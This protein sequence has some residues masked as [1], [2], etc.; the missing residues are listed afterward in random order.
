MLQLKCCDSSANVSSLL[1]SDFKDMT[2]YSYFN[3]ELSSPLST[4]TVALSLRECVDLF[5]TLIMH[6]STSLHDFLNRHEQWMMIL[7]TNYLRA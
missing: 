4:S 7:M 1:H 6:S 3:L 2:P 5:L